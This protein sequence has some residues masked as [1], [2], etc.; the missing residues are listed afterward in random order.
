MRISEVTQH[1]A[2]AKEAEFTILLQSG[3]D[4]M[5]EMVAFV[6]DDRNADA[7]IYLGVLMNYLVILKTVIVPMIL[8]ISCTIRAIGKTIFVMHSAKS[9][10]AQNGIALA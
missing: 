9:K 7:Y 2:V 5:D 10:K 1:P 6:M 8:K 3:E 4:K